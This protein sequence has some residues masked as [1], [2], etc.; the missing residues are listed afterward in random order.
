M[1][2]MTARVVVT[3][4][5]AFGAVG[6]CASL[7]SAT[8]PDPLHKVTICHATA[9]ASNPYVVITVDIA[10]IVGDSGHGHS[11][12]NVGDIIPRFAIDGYVYPGNNWDTAH[13]AILDNDCNVPASTPTTGPINQ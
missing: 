1:R 3:A 8:K 12:V 7:A 9:S 5:V 4:L 11:G 6:A 10:S 13:Q 2:R